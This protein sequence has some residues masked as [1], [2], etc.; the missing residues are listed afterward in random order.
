MENY[1]CRI[2]YDAYM[3]K[4]YMYASYDATLSYIV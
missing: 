1:Y 2:S 3:M 4:T